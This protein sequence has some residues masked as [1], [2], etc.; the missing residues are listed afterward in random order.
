MKNIISCDK[1]LATRNYYL[2]HE[3]HLLIL[4]VLYVRLSMKL[5]SCK[6]ILDK[7][8]NTQTKM[9]KPQAPTFVLNIHTGL[10]IIFY[11]EI[12][13]YWFLIRMSHLTSYLPCGPLIRTLLSLSKLKF[14]ILK[15]MEAPCWAFNKQYNY[16]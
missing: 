2:I 3:M 13:I 6:K 16:D 1:W 10:V 9:F 5:N 12:K 15:S 11:H 7:R 8:F 14:D 4:L